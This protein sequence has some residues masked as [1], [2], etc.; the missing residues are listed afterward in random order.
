[1]GASESFVVGDSVVIDVEVRDFLTKALSVSSVEI[2]VESPVT[3]TVEWLDVYG[4]AGEYG[5]VYVPTEVGWHRFIISG[6]NLSF[7]RNGTFYVH[8]SGIIVG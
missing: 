3:E 2:S 1:M 7:V 4:S 5:G 8:T 6:T